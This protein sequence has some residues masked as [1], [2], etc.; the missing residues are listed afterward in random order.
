MLLRNYLQPLLILLTALLVYG[1]IKVDHWDIW[2]VLVLALALYGI[3]VDS[4]KIT[5]GQFLPVGVFVLTLFYVIYKYA[6]PMWDHVLSIELKSVHHIFHWN[7]WF[8]SIPFNDGSLFRLWQPDW[9]TAYLKWAYRYGFALSFWICVIRAF[10]TKD[11]KKMGLYSLAGYLLQVPL[12]LPF[13]NTV[14]LQEVW[15]VLGQPDML[16]RHFTPAEQFAVS[17]N[18]FPSMH[19]S[20]AFAAILL[21]SREKS[22]W[23]RTIVTI[24]CSSIILAT[25]YLKIHWMIDVAGGMLFAYLVVK[26]ADF[27]VN[28][29]VYETMMSKVEQFGLKLQQTKLENGAPAPVVGEEE[30]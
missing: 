8:R 30:Y 16:A 20:I 22:K 1:I 17:L 19:T 4:K 21:V 9:L 28:S 18:C 5:W 23:Y 13:Y 25:L 29:R 6:N 10:F 11:V 2:C 26:L 14:F 12:I 7:E 27:I 15:Y 24:Y 3:K